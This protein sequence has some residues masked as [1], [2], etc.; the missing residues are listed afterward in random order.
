MTDNNAIVATSA[1]RSEPVH[2]AVRGHDR[3]FLAALLILFLLAVAPF[4]LNLAGQDFWLDV[5]LRAMSGIAAASLNL[6]IGSAAS[7]ASGHAVFLGYRGLFGRDPGKH[8]HH[9]RRNST[10]RRRYPGRSLCVCDRASSPC[11]Q[12]AF[13]SS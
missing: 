2:D 13:I 4:V 12:G 5:L 6:I 7:S 8:G 9:E 10:C 11:G 3:D 1:E